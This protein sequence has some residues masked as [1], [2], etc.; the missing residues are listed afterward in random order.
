[1]MRWKEMRLTS[2]RREATGRFKCEGYQHPKLIPSTIAVVFILLLSACFIASCLV[3]HHKFLR[4]K[5]GTRVF[6][7]P[8]YH[9]MLTCIREKSKMKGSTWNCCPVD[10]R[11][12]QSN[13]YIILN[14]NKTWAESVRNCTGMGANL[15]TISTEAEQNFIIQFLN[16]QFSYFLGLTNQNS[17]GQWQWL[18]RTPF[19]PDMVFWHKGEP[20]NHQEERCAVIVNEKDKWGWNNIPCQFETNRICKK[21]ATAFN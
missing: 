17:E 6:K 10:W 12:F 5:R 1:M 21:P 9:S 4:C 8:E 15:V 19:N 16:T 14:D 13:C 11:A 18:D 20:N 7:L 2:E 3:T